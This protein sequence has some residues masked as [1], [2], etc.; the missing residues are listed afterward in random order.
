MRSSDKVG[1]TYLIE[2][3]NTSKIIKIDSKVT[4]SMKSFNIKPTGSLSTSN[5][6]AISHPNEVSQFRAKGKSI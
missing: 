3:A 4:Y 2:M 1:E 5:Y 6:L